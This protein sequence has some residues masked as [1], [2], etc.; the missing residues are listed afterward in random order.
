VAQTLLNQTQ[1][2]VRT[3]SDWSKTYQHVVDYLLLIHVRSVKNYSKTENFFQNHLDNYF[4]NPILI[5]CTV[6]LL[7][8]DSALQMWAGENPI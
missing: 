3:G 6:M 2:F 1:Y 5:V 8:T 7:L 4:T